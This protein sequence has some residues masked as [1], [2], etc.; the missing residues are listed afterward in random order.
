MERMPISLFGQDKEDVQMLQKRFLAIMG[1][2]GYKK[3]TNWTRMHT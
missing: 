2:S 1:V 3:W